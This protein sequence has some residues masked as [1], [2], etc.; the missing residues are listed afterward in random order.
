MLH[1]YRAILAEW[2]GR[3]ADAVSEAEVART[4][5]PLSPAVNIELGR[6]FF[7]NAQYDEAEKQL[8]HTLELD[9]ASLRAHLHLGQ[10]LTYQRR[11]DDG[12]RE[13]QIA[14]RLSTNS[15]RP[16][17]LLAHAYA[18]ARRRDDALRLRDSLAARERR[19]YVPAFDFAI[20]HAGL[21]NATQAIDYL[22]RAVDDHSIR[23]YLMDPTFDGIR[24]DARF[25]ELLTRLRLPTDDPAR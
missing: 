12:I 20:V 13:L 10:L 11:F 17:A 6:A 21:G 7:F 8:R 3:Y 9:S 19:G 5:D 16:L 14:T 4:L 24:S 2:T 1:V 23:P 18:V 25:R 22:N 15:S